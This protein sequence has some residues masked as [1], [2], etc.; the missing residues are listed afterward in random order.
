MRLVALL[1]LVLTL[2]C[3]GGDGG[4]PD[5]GPPGDS[6]SPEP[7]FGDPT[8]LI[9]VVEAVYRVEQPFGWS[10]VSARFGAGETGFL[11]ETMRE[12]NCRL[13]ESD[14]SYC[15]EC[16]T[17][18]CI[19][20][21]CRAYP[22]YRSAGRITIDGLSTGVTL[23][24][25]DGWYNVDQYQL[26]EDLFDA[27]AG[28][29]ASAPGAEVAAFTVQATGVAPID[30]DLEQ[31][32]DG[33]LT[34]VSGQDEVVTWSEPGD[35]RV[36]LWMPSQTGAHGLP[37]NAV[38]E[39]EG[40]DT[41]SIRIPSALIDAFP[42]LPRSDTCQGVACVLID[43]PPSTIA[44]HSTASAAAGDQTVELRIESQVIFTLIHEG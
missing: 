41:G 33:E 3:G 14:A 8:N 35:G 31:G 2:A 38:I 23:S 32:C 30:P 16:T 43:C 4:G 11:T 40:P 1:P 17:G 10:G 13:L 34:L 9:S 18:L 20:G 7:Q 36:R 26:P 28:I 37:P 44:R 29:T 6:G 5:A 12:G 39:C 15:Q 21:E 19:G 27:G 42:V 24:W 22:T 25:Q